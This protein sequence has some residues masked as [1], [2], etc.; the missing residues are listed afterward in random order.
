[1]KI[2]F[3]SNVDCRPDDMCIDIAP[4]GVGDGGIFNIRCN[5]EALLCP[6]KKR[7]YCERASVL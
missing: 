4:T 5:R 7:H 2:R 1:M 3:P 6:S